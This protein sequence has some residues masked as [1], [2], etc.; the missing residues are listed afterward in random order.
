MRRLGAAVLCSVLAVS[1]LPAED[2]A[3]PDALLAEGI[4]LVQQGDFEAAVLKL[5]EASRRLAADPARKAARPPAAGIMRPLAD[6]YL[7]LGIS[8]L[9]LNQEL[10]A[11]AKFR[12]VLKV[13]PTRKLSDRVFS[14]QIIRVFEAARVELFPAEKK[15]RSVL[16]L[17]FIAG[18]GA[19]SAAVVVANSGGDTT[20][21]TAPAAATT[22]TL[23]T[24]G[25]NPTTTTST[26]VATDPGNPTTTTTT[27]TTTTLPGAS[28]TT[29]STTLPGSTTTTLPGSTTTTTSSTT[30]TTTTTTTTLP[31]TTTTTLPPTTTTTM[32]CTYALAPPQTNIGG[33]L[34]GGGTC[35]VTTQPGC[36]W[37]A[38]KSGDGGGNWITFTTPNSG[39]GSGAVSY[40]VPPLSIGTRTGF[41]RVG[42]SECVVVESLGLKAEPQ[43]LGWESL[44]DVPGGRGQVVIDGSS[45]RYQDSGLQQGTI[46][47]ATGTRQ[48]VAQLVTA[49]GPGTWTFRLAGSARPGSL[50]PLAGVP[51]QVTADSITFRLAGKAGERVVL[52]F[53]G[54]P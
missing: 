43:G 22:T 29:T 19:A 1:L 8:F 48:V 49:K 32:A 38:T 4:A 42:S 39:V 52:I 23:A 17:L 45:V 5:D 53:E 54:L 11:R 16:P 12:E 25:G 26:T 50:R 51:T 34:G 37:T 35:S 28:T 9:E 33:L 41:I 30:T 18:G 7:Y 6:A 27:T 36:A 24:G 2:G 13:E 44:L 31:P 40:T 47:A 3:T 10:N 15:K 14:P 21:T 20:T 46:A